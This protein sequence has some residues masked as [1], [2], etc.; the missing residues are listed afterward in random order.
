LGLFQ[1]R[2][3]VIEIGGVV[4]GKIAQMGR[5]GVSAKMAVTKEA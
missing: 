1:K 4:L 3:D 2:H 5:G